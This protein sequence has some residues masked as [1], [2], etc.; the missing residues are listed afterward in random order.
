MISK[1]K[2]SDSVDNIMHVFN[3]H[4]E[5]FNEFPVQKGNKFHFKKGF[6]FIWLKVNQQELTEIL[7]RMSNEK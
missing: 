5:K 3:M 7:K 6:V 1:S 4:Y 2:V